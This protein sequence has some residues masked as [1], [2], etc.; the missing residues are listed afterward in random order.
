MQADYIRGLF[1][2][3]EAQLF[4]VQTIWAT[5]N[6]PTVW[7]TF[8]WHTIVRYP[9]ISSCDCKYVCEW[10][11]KFTIEKVNC[12]LPAREFWWRLHGLHIYREW[13]KETNDVKMTHKGQCPVWKKCAWDTIRSTIA[14]RSWLTTLNVFRSTGQHMADQNVSQSATYTE[15]TSLEPRG[16]SMTCINCFV[17]QRKT[18]PTKYLKKNRHILFLLRLLRVKSLRNP[19]GPYTQRHDFCVLTDRGDEIFKPIFLH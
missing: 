12:Y 17:F 6:P 1:V 10:V 14:C 15:A 2:C 5:H 11:G 19:K 9:D 16:Q 13:K 7:N 4:C 18:K 3:H 8:L